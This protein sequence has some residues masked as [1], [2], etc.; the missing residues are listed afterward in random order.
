MSWPGPPNRAKRGRRVNFTTRP[1]MY[2]PRKILKW[3]ARIRWRYAPEAGHDRG[4]VERGEETKRRV[5]TKGASR[6][7]E[8]GCIWES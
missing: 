4:V 7:E 5:T 1:S 6:A 3:M 2:P 8:G